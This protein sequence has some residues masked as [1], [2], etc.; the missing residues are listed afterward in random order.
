MV[1]IR[2]IVALSAA[3]GVARKKVR[4]LALKSGE[5]RLAE[6]L[7]QLAEATHASGPRRTRLALR[8]SRR[9]LAQMIGVSTETVIRLL[10]RLKQK[11]AI[12]TSRRELIIADAEQLQRIAN[13]DTVG[14]A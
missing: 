7:I 6:L 3:L 11:Q 14:T 5:G 1:G 4:A 9:D 8:Y 2:L 10:A 13:Q 12:S